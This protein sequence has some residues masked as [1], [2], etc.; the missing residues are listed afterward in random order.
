MPRIYDDRDCDCDTLRTENERLTSILVNKTLTFD[1]ARELKAEN[2]R[3][4][5]ELHMR[6]QG[7]VAVLKKRDRWIEMAG[8]L[9]EQLR[10]MIDDDIDRPEQALAEFEAF[11]KT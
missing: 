2:E 8:E 6:D 1:Q 3:L 4:R 9:A 11:K 7:D 10:H 5:A